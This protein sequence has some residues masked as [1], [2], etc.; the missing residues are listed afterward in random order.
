MFSYLFVYSIRHHNSS[1][2]YPQSRHAAE[3]SAIMYYGPALWQSAF[4]DAEAE[5][6]LYGTAQLKLVLD[7]VIIIEAVQVD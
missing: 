2:L 7:S 3:I 6:V 1:R 4:E 5:A